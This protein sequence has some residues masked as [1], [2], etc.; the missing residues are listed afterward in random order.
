MAA[1]PPAQE[2]L[3]AKEGQGLGNRGSNAASDLEKRKTSS[4]IL[5]WNGLCCGHGDPRA[6]GTLP[7][8]TYFKLLQIFTDTWKQI[9]D[10]DRLLS[11]VPE[12]S[13]VRLQMGL[14]LQG[15]RVCVAGPGQGVLPVVCRSPL[16]PPF[17]QGP[18]QSPLPSPTALC[19]TSSILTPIP[20]STQLP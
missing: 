14:S 8:L 11:G 6:G 4:L 3:V 12:G 16:L 1:L 13:Q 5:I 17:W 10:T 7:S 18:Q 2:G 9:K 20:G 19:L 15:P